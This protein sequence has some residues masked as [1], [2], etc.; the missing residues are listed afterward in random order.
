MTRLQQVLL[1]LAI[2]ARDAMPKGGALR[3]SLSHVTSTAAHLPLPGMPGGDW[4]RI[5]VTDTGT[6]IPDELLSHIF[7]PFQS[8]KA[9]GKGTGLGL[10]QVH[11]LVSQHQGYIGVHTASGAGTTF[12][13][14][15]PPSAKLHPQKPSPATSPCCT[16]TARPSSSSRTTPLS[17]RHST[18]CSSNGAT[19]FS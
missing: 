12:T 7:E 4:V 19:R 18:I 1:N 9:P 6:G 11:G 16:A 17:A 5:A 13:I 3:F 10:A 15:L 2:N 8:T 14:Y